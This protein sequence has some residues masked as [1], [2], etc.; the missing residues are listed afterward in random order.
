MFE[1]RKRPLLSRRE[2]VARMVRSVAAGMACIA[3]ALGL[4]MLGYHALVKLS[5]VDSFENAAMILS[6]MGP[7]APVE[8]DAGK[9]FAGFYAL[10][11]GLMFVTTMGIVFAP[12]FHR[13]IHKFHLAED[14]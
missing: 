10:F 5:W 13:F 6:G 12:V 1:H 4:G 3:G 8:S 2:F 7:V 14:K 11:S 9:L